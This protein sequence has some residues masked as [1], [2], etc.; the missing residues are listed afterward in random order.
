MSE[1]DGTALSL[2]SLGMNTR[3]SLR[4]RRILHECV[5]HRFAIPIHID[6]STGLD[7]GYQRDA[8]SNNLGSR[9]GVFRMCPKAFRLERLGGASGDGLWPFFGQTVGRFSAKLVDVFRPSFWT[10]FVQ[11]FGQFSS[12]TLSVFRPKYY[13]LFSF[14]GGSQSSHPT[15]PSRSSDFTGELPKFHGKPSQI[16]AR[17]Y[18]FFAEN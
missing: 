4:W 12:N 6:T 10:F 17:S 7:V 14:H 3:L 18:L 13:F 15:R 8:L 9:F 1:L 11:N 5:M 2:A 16:C